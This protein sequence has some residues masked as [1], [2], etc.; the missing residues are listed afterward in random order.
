MGLGFD[1]ASE[2]A[3]LALAGTVAQQS[4]TWYAVLSLPL[5]F[6]AGMT[7]LDTLDGVAMT[8]AY[9]W[10]LHQPRM[11]RIYNFW[12]TGLSGLGALVIGVV[13]L[14]QWAGEHFPAVGR[15]LAALQHVDVS[16][17]GFWLAGFT[18]GLFVVARLQYRARL[19]GSGRQA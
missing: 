4:L 9:G 8:H 3:L 15:A 5:L 11:K 13:T 6:A 12:V 1:T 2:V 7:L 10:A 17:L 19:R 18:L 16:S 14:A